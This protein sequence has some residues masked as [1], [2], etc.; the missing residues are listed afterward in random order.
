MIAA[1]VSKALSGSNTNGPI[2]ITLNVDRR[3]IGKVV[4][5]EMRHNPEFGR[6]MTKQLKV[7]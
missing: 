5:D 4:I 1:A 6:Q 3:Q 7:A 2:H